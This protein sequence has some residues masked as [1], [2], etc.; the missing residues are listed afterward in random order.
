MYIYMYSDFTCFGQS[1]FSWLLAY[2]EGEYNIVW[3]DIGIK[4]LSAVG[5]SLLSKTHSLFM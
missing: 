4:L 1:Q 2:G 3:M 5:V